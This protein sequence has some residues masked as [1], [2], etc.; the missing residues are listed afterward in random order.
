[1][2]SPVVVAKSPLRSSTSFPGGLLKPFRNRRNGQPVLLL[3]G[4]DPRLA[5]LH[6]FPNVGFGLDG[7]A[8]QHA[9]RLVAAETKGLLVYVDLVLTLIRTI[10]AGTHYIGM[11]LG[12]FQSCPA[13]DLR[14]Q[15]VRCPEP[16]PRFAKRPRRG[17][18]L[19]LLF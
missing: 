12:D 9:G 1:V 2:E 8:L 5:Q 14:V 7:I 15:P 18:M 6:R 10:D 3:L 4:C 17:A 13:C 16:A 11:F 19:V